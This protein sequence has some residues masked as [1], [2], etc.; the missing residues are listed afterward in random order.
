MK[1]PSL[2]SQKKV[3]PENLAGLGA[4][5]LAQILAEVAETRTDLKRR[6]RMELA[7]GLGASHL[8][9]EIDKRL[10]AV[11]TSRG[12]VTWRQ[13]PAFLR[14][15]DAVRGLIADR[16]ALEDT[17]GA[18]ERLWRLLA[19]APQTT[20]RLREH[21]EALDAIYRRAAQDQGQLMAGHDPHLAAQALI[22]AMAAQ[23]RAWGAWLAALLRA[24]GP[25]LAKVALPMAQARAAQPGWIPLVRDLADAA[26]DV[27]VFAATYSPAALQ[28][29]PVAIAVARRQ[30]A[31]GRIEAMGQALRL[32]APKPSGFRGRLGAPDFD[33]ES[34]WIDYLEAAG[35]LAGAQAVRWASFQRTLDLS[36]A[37]AFTS[38]LTG[39]DDVEAEAA[40]LAHAAGHAD[41]EEGLAV[42]M[43]WPALPE[44]SA[45]ITDRAGDVKVAPE[46]AELWAGK[47]RKRFPAAAHILLRKGA[48]AAF[49]QRAFKLCDRL[50]EEADAIGLS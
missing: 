9:P 39:F 6:L 24:A 13:K 26:G 35:D 16:L 25:A 29:P 8:V 3:T 10:A 21:D 14:D 45:M 44:A 15:L 4:E 36:R 7:A 23:P 5:R 22:D 41:F 11:E 50:T 27:E 49:K 20:K 28:T 18:S 2:A 47:L 48:A 38:R 12:Q 46:L 31:A 19:T 33:W 42:L 1:T 32:A 17:A 40:A 34:A 43:G 30:M 37:K